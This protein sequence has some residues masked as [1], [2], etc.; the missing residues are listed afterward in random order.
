M[1]R[2]SDQIGGNNLGIRAAIRDHQA[3][4]WTSNHINPNAA[5]QNAFG[6]SHK[7]IARSR[8]LYLPQAE[9]NSPKVMEATPWTPPMAKI[10]SAPQ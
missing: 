2:L 3:V 6:L 9:P 1:L 8:Q 5:K 7:L 10:L 4:S